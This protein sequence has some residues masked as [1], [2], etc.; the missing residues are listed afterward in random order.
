[1]QHEKK[2]ALLQ[3]LSVEVVVVVNRLYRTKG[4]IVWKLG[5]VNLWTYSSYKR[6]SLHHK[7]CHSLPFVVDQ[8]ILFGAC[9]E[10]YVR[11]ISLHHRTQD[12]HTLRSPRKALP[13]VA[14]KNTFSRA[15]ISCQRISKAL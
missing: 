7:C 3:H 9:H 12:R 5:I 15:A 6:T 4:R 11:L 10:I 2:T 1:M 8:K 13:R 14:L